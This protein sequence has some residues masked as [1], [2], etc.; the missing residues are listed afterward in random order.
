ML[1][2]PARQ[3]VADVLRHLPL[4]SI[5][6]ALLGVTCVASVA[7]VAR[8]QQ[9]SRDVASVFFVAKSENRNQ[10]HYGVH[11]DEGCAPTTRAPVFAYWRMLERGPL[12]TEPLLALEVRAYGVG[13][14]R[15]LGREQGGGR[16]AVAL[17]AL[18]ARTIVVVSQAQ[19]EACRADA[20]T[21]IGG[22]P[23]AL[24]SVYA[25]LG[26]PFGVA[27]LLLSGRG[28]DGREVRERVVP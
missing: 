21:T 20:T 3:S 17:R 26:W 8:G 13:E 2:S 28:P 22:A 16:V 4:P 9:R 6:L 14:Q 10:V 12:A 7:G 11:L 24:T 5:L 27:Y 1:P 23:A 15:V 25:K 18:P 19:G